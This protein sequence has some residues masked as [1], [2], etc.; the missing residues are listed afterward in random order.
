MSADS[1]DQIEFLSLDDVKIQ[2][3]NVRTRDIDDGIDD[4]ASS[5]KALGLLQPITAYYDSANS[6][7][8]VLAGQ[9]RLNAHVLLNEKYPKDGFDKIKAILIPEPT[10]SDD[11]I[12]LS[13]AENITHLGM[14]QTDLI[15]AVTDLYNV[16]HDYDMVQEK[17]GLTRYVVN[18]YVKLARLPQKIIDA[19]NDGEISANPQTAE[20]AAIRAVDALRS[21]SSDS[22]EQLENVIKLARNY[23]SGEFQNEDLDDEARKGGDPD[24]IAGRARSK[25]KKKFTVN[26]SLEV[27][28]KLQRVSEDKGEKEVSTATSFIV[29]GVTDAYKDLE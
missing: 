7:Y 13:L 14:H 12:A 17:F 29:K 24:Q 15:K 2:K 20:N 1:N 23:A 19:I 6:R 4:L 3:H 21:T 9:R 26:L 28:E 18:K 10:N 25:V 27:A 22:D 16:Y 8:V 11:K 5:I